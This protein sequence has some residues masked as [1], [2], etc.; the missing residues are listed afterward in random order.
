MS[1][2]RLYKHP[3]RGYF[4]KAPRQ[5][6]GFEE[7]RAMLLTTLVRRPHLAGGGYSGETHTGEA[8]YVRGSGELRDKLIVRSIRNGRWDGPW[9]RETVSA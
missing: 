4:H 1:R 2:G 7:M 8:F 3:K 5:H 6:L 9:R